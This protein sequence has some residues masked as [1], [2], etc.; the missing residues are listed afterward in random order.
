MTREALA[1]RVRDVVSDGDWGWNKIPFEFP[2]ATKRELQANHV[3]MA[4][5]EGDKLTWIDSGHGMFS[6]GST[7]KLATK[8]EHGS[9]FGAAGFGRLRYCPRFKL[10]SCC[11]FIIAKE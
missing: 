8:V 3:A 1:L 11:A 9:L 10:L 7:Y 6:I 4:S 2:N 5:K